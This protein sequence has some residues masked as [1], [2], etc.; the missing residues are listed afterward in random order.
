MTLSGVLES[1]AHWFG[2]THTVRCDPQPVLRDTAGR[3]LREFLTEFR[4]DG[5]TFGDSVI[6]YDLA[7]AERLVADMRSSLRIVGE[8]VARAEL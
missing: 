8:L 7:D 4:I 3:E 2:L 6:A 5:R 1:F